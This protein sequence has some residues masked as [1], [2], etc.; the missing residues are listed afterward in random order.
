MKNTA[1]NDKIKQ[2]LAVSGATHREG[3]VYSI[4]WPLYERSKIMD[5]N[6]KLQNIIDYVEI[7]L[8]KKEEPVDTEEIA[9]MAGCSY[10]F[11]QRVFSYMNGFSF[12]EYIRGRK[13]TLAGYD[14]KCTDIKVVDVS[15]KY[16]YESPTSFTKAFVQFHGVTPS[17][18]RDTQV[19]LQVCSRLQLCGHSR[20]AWCLVHKSAL[21]LIGKTVKINCGDGSQ[22]VKIPGFWN[23]CQKDGTFARLIS[24]DTAEIKGIFGLFGSFDKDWID[25]TIAV[26]S[27]TAEVEGFDEILVPEA[28]WAV[29]DCI[30]PVPQSIQNGWKYLNEEWLVKYPF[31]HALCP[32]LEWYSDGNV[33]SKDYLSQIWIPIIEEE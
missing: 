5:W 12:A 17:Q 11:F 10:N 30:G 1:V 6:D 32:E 13:L 27:V 7:H 21:R 15:Y 3:A 19:P 22:S 20:L 9:R 2:R 24:M 18:A 25:Y 23:D 8:Q 31:R 33:Y 4:E 28:T 26:N 14:L 29:F 16:G